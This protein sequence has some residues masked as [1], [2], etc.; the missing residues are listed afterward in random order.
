[1]RG[2][3]I[4][5]GAAVVSRINGVDV[6]LTGEYHSIVVKQRD[7]KGVLAHIATCL[8]VYDINIATT[9]LFRERKG[10]IAYT[11]MQTDDEIDEAIARAIAKNP[12][13]YDVRI[14]KSDRATDA[15][16]PVAAESA[17]PLP[18]FGA[19]MTPEKAA[20]LFESLDFT[21]GA[22]LLAYLSVIHM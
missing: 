12:D 22:E 1:M 5:G 6:R 9:R 19:D 4:G 10:H 17:C 11:I 16:P 14:V 18:G 20:E 21:S 15:V 7:V 8:N 3:S 2:E 13:I